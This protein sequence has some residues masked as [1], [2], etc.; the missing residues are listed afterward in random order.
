MWLLGYL[1]VAIE[2]QSLGFEWVGTRFPPQVDG[3]NL[4]GLVAQLV[5]PT[6]EVQQLIGDVLKQNSPIYLSERIPWKVVSGILSSILMINKR[7]RNEGVM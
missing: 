5:H 1:F 3:V 4:N 7:K 6:L 2:D